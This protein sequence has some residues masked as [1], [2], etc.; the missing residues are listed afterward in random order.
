MLATTGNMASKATPPNTLKTLA[1][2]LLRNGG[3][4]FFT[5]LSCR[6]ILNVAGWQCKGYRAILLP[7]VMGALA[8]KTLTALRGGGT[9]PPGRL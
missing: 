7:R 4:E 3:P 8:P 1:G 6:N 5:G 9:L 2:F